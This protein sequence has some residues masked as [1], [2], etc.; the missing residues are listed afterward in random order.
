MD[1]YIAHIFILNIVLVLFDVSIGYHLA[2][3]LCRG[4]E[5]GDDGQRTLYGMRRF[6]SGVVALYTL[7]NCIAYS[8][9][10]PVF[11]ILVT[12]IIMIDMVGQ[13]MVRRH[14]RKDR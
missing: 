3:L 9:G 11:L 13:L 10:S 5:D 2:P 14:L 4:T 7:L 8:K 6:L 12:G 1:N